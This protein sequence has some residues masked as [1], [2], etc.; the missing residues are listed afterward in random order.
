[1]KLKRVL[2]FVIGLFE[3]ALPP[4]DQ[5]SIKRFRLGKMQSYEVLVGDFNRIE[6]EASSIGTHFAFAL[7]CL[8]VAIT[9]HITLSRVRISDQSVREPFMLLMF[10]CY[11][12]GAFF[13]I[14]AFR[15]RGRLRKFMQVIRDSQVP[16]LGEKGSE[17]GP[18]EADQ[19]PSIKESGGSEG[20]PGGAQ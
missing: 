1:M 9:I 19:L 6:D 15:Q 8:P 4:D 12:L 14:S 17:I 20:K 11:I 18:S 13:A 3:M 16:P 10:A 7:A 5:I 2:G